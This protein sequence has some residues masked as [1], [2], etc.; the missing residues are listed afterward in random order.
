MRLIIAEID[1]TFQIGHVL[2]SSALTT[3]FEKK[4]TKNKIDRS[5]KQIKNRK[6]EYYS[7]FSIWFLLA[8]HPKFFSGMLC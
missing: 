3:F 1:R 5:E 4:K 6:K 2:E 7:N 8:I